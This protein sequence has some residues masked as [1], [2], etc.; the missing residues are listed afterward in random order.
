MLRGNYTARVDEKGRL[1]VPIHFRRK[2]EE[3]YGSNQVYVT[4][5]RGDSVQIFPLLEWEKVEQKLSIL[6]TNETARIIY[7]T[8]TSFWGQESEIDNQGRILIHP[9]L[10]R[11]AEVYGDVAVLGQLTYLNVWN[12]EKIEKFLIENPFTDEHAEV[13]ARLGI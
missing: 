13:L 3:K 4:S 11:K 5:L 7:V 6:P 12:L 2:I 1:K 8:S 10:R 9:L